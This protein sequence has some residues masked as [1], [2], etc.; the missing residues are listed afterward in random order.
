MKIKEFLIRFVIVFA[1]VFVVNAVVVYLWN[2]IVHGE[3]AFNWGLSFT[4]AIVVGI[5]LPLTRAMTSKEK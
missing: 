3:G 1:V 2:L 5:I 4:L